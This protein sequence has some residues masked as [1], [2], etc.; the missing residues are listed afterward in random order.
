MNSTC[1]SIKQSGVQILNSTIDLL[2]SMLTTYKITEGILWNL[3][4]KY[5]FV[6]FIA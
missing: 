2:V 1:I 6:L 3:N 4:T 5:I